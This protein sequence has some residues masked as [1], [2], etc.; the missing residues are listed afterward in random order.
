MTLAIQIRPEQDQDIHDITQ[1]TELAFADAPHSSHTEH[2]IVNALREQ[3]QLTISLVALLDGKI[4][5]HIAISPVNISSGEKN[6]Y[7]LGPISVLPKY[8]GQGVGSALIQQALQQLKNLG[9]EGCVLLGEPEYYTRFG[10][11]VVSGLTLAD[12]PAEYF[13][14]LSFNGN[15]AQGDVTYSSAF[16]ATA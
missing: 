10:F 4:I 9:A 3:Q 7:G 14:A 5:G 8:Q 15:F 2:F 6:W 11:Q 13:Q 12:V 1:V 16:E